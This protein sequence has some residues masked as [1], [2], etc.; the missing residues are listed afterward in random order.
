MIPKTVADL[1]RVHC[2][3]KVDAGA[4]TFSL[5]EKETAGDLLAPNGLSRW[6]GDLGVVRGR[7]PGNVGALA[8]PVGRFATRKP[9]DDFIPSY[10]KDV[11]GSC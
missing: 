6:I 4:Q 11:E 8:R 9:F 10:E 1:A 3:E 2:V 7:E 5:P